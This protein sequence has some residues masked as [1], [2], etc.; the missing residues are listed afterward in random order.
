MS[1]IGYAR[2]S[3]NDQHPEAQLDA[4]TAAGCERIFTDKMSGKLASRP[5]LELAL[6]YVREG[7]VFVVTKL[8]RLGRTMKNL[9]ELG[10]QLERQ[11][12]ALKVLASDIDTTTPAGKLFFHMLAGFAEFEHALIVERTNEGLAAARARGR[13]GGA[14]F[15]MTPAKAKMAQRMY[16]SRDYT[17]AQIADA[18]GVS[19]TS[20]Y[21]YLDTTPKE[22]T[23]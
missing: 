2:V 9:I 1:T 21:R 22:T 17:L 13:R 5:E 11:G 12:V 8:D 14:P 15:K 20:V 3:T 7:D 18:V 10:L 16:D 23:P 4:L 19:K 6:A